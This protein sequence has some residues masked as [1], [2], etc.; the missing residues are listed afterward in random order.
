MVYNRGVTRFILEFLIIVI[1]GL[2]LMN[3]SCGAWL[4]AAY[5]LGLLSRKEGSVHERRNAFLYLLI[6]E[7]TNEST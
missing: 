3:S 6:L 1:K 4:A 5:L 7:I 2:F